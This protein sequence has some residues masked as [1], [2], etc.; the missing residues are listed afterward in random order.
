MIVNLLLTA[1]LATCALCD[2]KRRQLPLTVLLAGLLTGAGGMIMQT[3]LQPALLARL[4]LGALPG[5]VLLSVSLGTG[6]AVGLGDAALFMVSGVYLGFWEN[7]FLLLMSLLLAGLWG[8]GM[9]VTK[10]G[11]RKT[12]LPLAPFVLVSFAAL[13]VLKV[14]CR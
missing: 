4:F 5:A 11:G 9:L 3:G 12:T 7:L 1:V 13:E 10:M 6:G 2:I 8:T 14:V